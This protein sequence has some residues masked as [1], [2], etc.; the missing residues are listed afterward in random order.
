M[1]AADGAATSK[2][3]RAILPSSAHGARLGGLTADDVAKLR[4]YCAENFAASVVFVDS[5]DERATLPSAGPAEIV[6]LATRDRT[7]LVTSH[8]RSARAVLAKLHIPTT[9][10]KGTW[11][12]LEADEA[13]RATAAEHRVDRPTQLRYRAQ[14]AIESHGPLAASTDVA[15]FQSTCAPR[16]SAPAQAVASCSAQDVTED[17]DVK[18]IE[19]RGGSYRG[20][21]AKPFS[22]EVLR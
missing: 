3:F 14:S 11:L 1:A 10:L 20:G 21:A 19:L 16:E 9:G 6:W 22:F 12:V 17:S 15:A 8:R 13:V 5:L 4:R 2:S 18:V 7:R